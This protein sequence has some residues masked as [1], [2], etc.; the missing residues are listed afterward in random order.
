MDNTNLHKELD[1]IQ[2]CITRMAN[3]SFL[4]K[5]WLIT[6]IVAVLALTEDKVNLLFLSLIIFIPILCFWYLDAFFLHKE[7]MY[8][9]MYEWVLIE[10]AKDNLEFQY[11]LDADRFKNEV[12]PLCRVAFSNTLIVFY[13][14]PLLIDIIF[15]AKEIIPNCYCSY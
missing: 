14:I 3:N 11:N 6:L 12:K 9:K 15:F 1:L 8:R 10:R 5:G 4:L 7:K 13:G 2:N